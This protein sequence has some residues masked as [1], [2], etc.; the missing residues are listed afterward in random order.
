LISI[1]YL[2]DTLVEWQFR[3]P[4]ESGEELGGLGRPWGVGGYEAEATQMVSPQS[5]Q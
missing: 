1:W 2:G 3:R 5:G 4:K